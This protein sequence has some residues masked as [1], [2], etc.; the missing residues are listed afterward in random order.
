MLVLLSF[1]ITWG[2][3]WFFDLRMIP[4]ER[5]AREMWGEPGEKREDDER[6]PLLASAGHGGGQG[7]MLQ[8]FMEGSTLYEGSVGNF[9][10]PFESP[11]V[12]DDEEEGESDSHGVKIPRRFRRKADHPFSD[13]VRREIKPMSC[14][15]TVIRRG[16]RGLRLGQS[17]G[18]TQEQRGIHNR[19]NF[20]R[21]LKQVE[22]EVRTFSVTS[23][24]HTSLNIELYR[25]RRVNTRRWGTSSCKLP[26]RLSTL[27]TGSWRRSWTMATWCM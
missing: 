25:F 17:L 5:K 15:V 6:A 2:E 16:P 24:V 7:G 4:L 12:S 20:V 27:R 26:G 10:S 22:P 14:C 13:Q 9:Y 1:I 8:R 19:M 18:Q 3:V 21:L 23:S 11:E